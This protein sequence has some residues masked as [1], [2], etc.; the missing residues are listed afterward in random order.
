MSPATTPTLTSALLQVWPLL[1]LPEWVH[2]VSLIPWLNLL[3]SPQSTSAVSNTFWWAALRTSSY[4]SWPSW[5]AAG[6]S[7]QC[8]QLVRGERIL[9]IAVLLCWPSQGK[10][11]GASSINRHYG[12]YHRSP[13]ERSGTLLVPWLSIQLLGW[14]DVCCLG[15]LGRQ[16]FPPP[17]A[18]TQQHAGTSRVR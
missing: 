11:L 10:D 4:D 12:R 2:G 8:S 1:W 13:C 5:I 14:V 7:H 17:Y 3:I 6:H 18:L 16:V 15:I 9:W